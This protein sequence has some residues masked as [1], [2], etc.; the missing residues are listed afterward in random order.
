MGQHAAKKFGRDFGSSLCTLCKQLLEVLRSK[1]LS[2]G[3]K[4]SFDLSP[5]LSDE[6]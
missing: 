1:L 2:A 5:V 4:F 3:D 6:N